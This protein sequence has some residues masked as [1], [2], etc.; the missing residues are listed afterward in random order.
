MHG[1]A[2]LERTRTKRRF[3]QFTKTASVIDM[4]TTEHD[5]KI[6][7]RRRQAER[8]EARHGTGGK[9]AVFGVE[10]NS[11]TVRANHAADRRAYL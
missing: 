9:R 5:R 8:Y 3:F 7:E 10:G 4:T 11:G 6:A 2:N 1:N